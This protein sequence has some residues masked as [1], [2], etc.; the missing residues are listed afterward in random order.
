MFVIVFVFLIIMCSSAF[1]GVKVVDL[2]SSGGFYKYKE[3]YIAVHQSCGNNGDY[4]VQASRPL[5]ESISV[6]IYGSGDPYRARIA[7]YDDA[8][9]TDKRV[10]YSIPV[11][12]EALEGGYKANFILDVSSRDISHFYIESDSWEEIARVKLWDCDQRGQ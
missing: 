1:G 10:T 5:G 11:A 8:V 3:T 4:F 6:Y 12:L 9:K 2:V 7:I